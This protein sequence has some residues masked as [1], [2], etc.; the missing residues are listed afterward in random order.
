MMRREH[1]GGPDISNA[2]RVLQRRGYAI[3]PMPHTM[4][5]LMLS[6]ARRS[7][8]EVRAVVRRS[9]NGH[10]TGGVPLVDVAP[11][12]GVVSPNA[13]GNDGSRAGPGSPR[14]IL[15]SAVAEAEAHGRRVAAQAT[16]STSRRMTWAADLGHISIRA[17][18]PDAGVRSGEGKGDGPAYIFR[19]PLAPISAAHGVSRTPRFTCWPGSVGRGMH[20]R[21]GPA[22]T[23]E[24]LASERC[25]ESVDVDVPLGCVLV[26]TRDLVHSGWSS[27]TRLWNPTQEEE[28]RTGAEAARGLVW[29]HGRIHAHR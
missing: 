21:H 25:G 13:S 4:H 19:V 15:R 5:S 16:Q 29:V 10:I 18:E 20:A 28:S 6:R 1:N 23:E 22:L 17:G 9:A 12:L 8:A 24:I 2:A 3:L 26:Y 11:V 14:H 7:I 27:E